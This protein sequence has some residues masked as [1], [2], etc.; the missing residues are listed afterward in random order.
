MLYEVITNG[1]KRFDHNVVEC[2][3][4][5]QPF[6]EERGLPAELVVRHGSY[7]FV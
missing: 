2:L 5:L 7:N 6:A 1:G 4:V 3:A